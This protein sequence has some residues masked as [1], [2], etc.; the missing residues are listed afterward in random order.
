[1]PK[2]EEVLELIKQAN[3]QMDMLLGDTS[4]PKNVRN[5]VSEAK[6]KLNEEGDFTVRASSAIYN[7]DSVSND[8]NL[9]PQARTMIW[10]VL[11]IL[12]SIKD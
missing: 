3:V 10:G 5:A 7:L 8:I 11:S 2:K 1:M 9:P 12:E 6:T 4:V